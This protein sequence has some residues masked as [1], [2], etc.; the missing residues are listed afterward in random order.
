MR[1]IAKTNGLAI[2][3]RRN[4]LIGA[5]YESQ[6]RK[7]SQ[8]SSLRAKNIFTERCFDESSGSRR[9]NLVVGPPAFGPDG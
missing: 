6:D 1:A 3:S 9:S 5:K 8:H 7:R 2:E 4:K